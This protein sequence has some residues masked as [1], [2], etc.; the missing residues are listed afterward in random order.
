MERATDAGGWVMGGLVLVVFVAVA[1]PVTFALTALVAH[2][3][4][5][6]GRFIPVPWRCGAAPDR[7]KDAHHSAPRFVLAV[8]TVIFAGV[9]SPLA[10]GRLGPIGVSLHSLF[11][12][13]LLIALAEWL[14]AR[15]AR[16]AVWVCF[17]GMTLCAFYFGANVFGRAAVPAAFDALA[18]IGFLSLALRAAREDDR[19]R[20]SRV[21]DS[22]A[23]GS[24]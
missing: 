16:P 1:Y 11:Y 18:S 14:E 23:V 13:A 17:G 3:I 12:V 19:A 7:P 24:A 21:S 22:G 6:A 15:S 2:A 9:F 10:R 8:A 5:R 20:R 4:D